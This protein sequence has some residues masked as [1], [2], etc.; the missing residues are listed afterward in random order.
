MGKRNT[1]RRLAMQALYQADMAGEDIETALD[2]I[3]Q[4]DEFIEE[5]ISFAKKLARGAWQDRNELDKS[6]AGLSVD[7]PL[8]RIGKVDRSILRLA[9]QELRMKET[10]VSVVI[11]EAVEIAKKYSG[12]EAAKFINGILG[13]YVRQLP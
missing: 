13:A 2:N 7:W 11:N 3:A 4:S 12:A 9:I 1:S 10:P 5:T 8:D 6:I